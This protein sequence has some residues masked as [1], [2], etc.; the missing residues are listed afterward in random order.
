MRSSD[1]H[2]KGF[3]LTEA[4]VAVALLTIVWLSSVSVIITANAS[5]SFAKHKSQA[6]YLIQQKIESLRKQ[7]FSS[8]LGST[9]TVSV[10]TRGTPDST[11]DDLAGTQVVTVTTP[12]T[13]YKKVLIQIRWTE[14]FFGRSKTV[15]EY[16]GTF[17]A[18]D[19]Q[20]N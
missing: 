6:I 9:T 5:G 14:S 12:D 2:K 1:K 10:D 19:T 4:V 17:I 18:N 20:A 13:Y 15:S 8:I 7:T 11:T 3:S 16:G